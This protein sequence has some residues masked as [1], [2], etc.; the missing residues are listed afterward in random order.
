MRIVIV[1]QQWLGAEAL[2]LCLRRGDEVVKVLAPGAAGEEYD[3]LY[4][5]AQQAGLPVEVCRRRVEAGHIPPGVDL[6][7][8]A[9]AHAFIAPGARLATRYG[10][11]GYHPSLLPRHRGRDAVRW[12]I[13][14]GDPIAG[15]TAYWMDDGADTGPVAAQDWCHVRPGDDARTLWRRDL[16]P[17]GL[18]LI[19][20]VLRELDGGVV[21]SIPQ[22]GYAST[23]EPAFSSQR[24]SEV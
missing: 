21:T 18:R 23:W 7:V 14:M 19:D 5:A 6:I 1:G 12:T 11:L 22:P 15:G 2:K 8:A 9:H 13:H 10:A 17:M 24:L 3:R 20:K 16:A 4:A